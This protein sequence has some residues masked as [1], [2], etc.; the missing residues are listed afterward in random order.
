[1]NPELIALAKALQPF[2]EVGGSKN[3]KYKVTGF[4]SGTPSTPY[5]TGPA[6]LFGVL[7]LERDMISSR[8]QP[9]GISSSFPAIGTQDMNP[10]Y[11]YLTGFLDSSGAEPTTVCDDAPTAGNGKGCLQTA[12]FGRYSRQTRELEVNRLGQRINGGETANLTIMNDPM[13]EEI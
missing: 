12:V 8:I 11:A 6:G 4:P 1:M 7:G 3:P 2:I 5:Y 9:R 13:A 10:L